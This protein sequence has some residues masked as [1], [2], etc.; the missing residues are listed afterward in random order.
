MD[1]NVHDENALTYSTKTPLVCQYC[2]QPIES[3]FYYCPNCG[4]KLNVAP[5]STSAGTQAWIYAFSII[6]PMLCFIFVTKWPGLKY[7]RSK[8]P[9]TR[10]IGLNAIV[11]LALSTILTVW[12][13]YVW[14]QDAI[15]S[16]VNSINADLSSDMGS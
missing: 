8:D 13:A 1:P 4:N 6:L 3:S 2:H 16:S 9:A 7:Y 15:Q 5:L 12:L 10:S 11:L 14:T